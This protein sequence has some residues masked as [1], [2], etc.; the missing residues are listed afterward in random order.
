MGEGPLLDKTP[1]K[2]V[3]VLERETSASGQNRQRQTVRKL[4]CSVI[5][6]GRNAIFCLQ[7]RHEGSFENSTWQE[8]TG[9][10]GNLVQDEI[11]YRS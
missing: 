2:D 4:P 9:Q 11:L 8:G 3:L 7:R 10:G 6:V 5:K 1:R